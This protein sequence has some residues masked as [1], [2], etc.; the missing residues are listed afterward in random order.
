MIGKREHYEHRPVRDIKP[1]ITPGDALVERVCV[2]C[3]SKFMGMRTAVVCPPSTGR[4]CRQIRIKR[5]AAARYRAVT[6]APGEPSSAGALAPE[7]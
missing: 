3:G 4:N 2:E 7:P 1:M 6:R 5:K